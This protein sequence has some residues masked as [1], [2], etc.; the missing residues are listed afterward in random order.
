MY[1]TVAKTQVQP[2]LEQLKLITDL[3]FKMGGKRYLASWAELD[4][5]QWRLQFGDYWSKVNELKQKYDPK[6]VLNPGFIKYEH[7][8]STQVNQQPTPSTEAIISQPPF[9]LHLPENIPLEPVVTTSNS[10]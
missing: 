10:Q 2:V 4:L 6:G 3:A 9:S 5:P 1:P 7:I 8:T